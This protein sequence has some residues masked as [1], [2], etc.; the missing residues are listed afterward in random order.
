MYRQCID[1]EPTLKGIN[2]TGEH[3]VEDF[4]TEPGRP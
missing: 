4:E 2:E 1:G 3:G